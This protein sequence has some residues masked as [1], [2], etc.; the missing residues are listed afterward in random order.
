M[1][2]DEIRTGGQTGADRAAF[3]AARARGVP[4]SGWCPKGGWAE[5][6]PEPPGLLERYPEMLET[7][8]PEPIQ[9]TEWNIRDSSACI[10]FDTPGSTVSPGTRAGMPFFDAYGVPCFT[11]DLGTGALS[12]DD[13]LAAWVAKVSRG[14]YPFVLGV[15]GPR[16]SEYD[17]I[18]DIVF[19]VISRVIEATRR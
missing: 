14:C 1:A 10:V 19:A 11:Y 7:P 3:D 15:G 6:M 9:R 8:L 12:Q 18:Y 2:I 17:G 13:D 5:D 4:I 16:A